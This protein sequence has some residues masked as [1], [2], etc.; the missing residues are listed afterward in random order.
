MF[1]YKYCL[2]KFYIK[3]DMKYEK[4]IKFNKTKNVDSR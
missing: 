2:N 4:E 3:I 1:Q